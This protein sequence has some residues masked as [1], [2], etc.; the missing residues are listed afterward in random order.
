MEIIDELKRLLPEEQV[1]I[2]ELMKNHTSFKVGGNAKYYVIAKTIEDVKNIVEFVNAKKF[3]I[4]IIGNGTNLLVSDKGLDGIVLKISL[5]EIKIN[6]SVVEVSAGVPLGKLAQILLKEEIEGFEFA[7]GIPG[8][9]GGAI[10]MNAGAHGGEMKDC[11]REV[12]CLEKSTNKIVKFK[13]EECKF[14]YRNSIFSNNEYIIL[15]AKLEFKKGNKEEIQEKM[16]ENLKFRKEKQPLEYPSAGSTF[17]RG[18]D[19]ITAKLID[20]CGLKGYMV[21]GAQVSEKHAGFLINKQ[22]AKAKDIYNLINY[23]KKVVF[24][25]TGKTIELEVKLLGE[26]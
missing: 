5:Q 6:D 25:K 23:V 15:G 20:E 24:E 1:K 8:T 21:G 13:N 9:I 17:K 2:N 12:T 18:N 14:T 11:I 26:F 16:N 3:P 22:N 19:F 10:L 4:Y 7:G